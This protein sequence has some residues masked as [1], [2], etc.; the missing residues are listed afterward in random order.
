MLAH[1]VHVALVAAGLA[2]LGVLLGPTV[3]HRPRPGSRP[4]PG[5]DIHDARVGELRAAVARY[6]ADGSVSALLST[7]H[8]AADRL[9]DHRLRLEPAGSTV[10]VPLAVTGS[11]AAAGVHAALVPAHLRERALFGVFFVVVAVAQLAWAERGWRRP[12]HGWLLAGAAGNLAVL[13]LWAT[14]RT[15]GLPYGLLPEPEAVG[16]WDLTCA[17]FELAVVAA[18]VVG[19]RDGV[20]RAAPWREWHPALHAWTALAATALVVLTL[21][22]ATEMA[23]H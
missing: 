7:V 6:A 21:G 18:C 15:A 19:L 11:L 10:L 1:G 23:G 20:R 16:A 5:G 8:G 13:A 12:T 22:G 2:G 4:A 14:T 17:A 3:P 9:R